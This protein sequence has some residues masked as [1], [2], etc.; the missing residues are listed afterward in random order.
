MPSPSC[1]LGFTTITR[2]IATTGTLTPALLLPAPEQVS[3]ITGLA[4]PDIPSPATPCTP[5]RPCFWLR[6]G[7][8]SD[9][10]CVA[11]GGAS[12]FVHGSLSRQ[13]HQAVSS[14]C[15]GA[16]LPRCSTDYPLTSSCSPPRVAT[17]QLLSATR[18]EAPPVRD[19]TLCAVTLSSARAPVWDRLSSE[20]NSEIVRFESILG[21]LATVTPKAGHRPALRPRGL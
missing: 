5:F 4:L 14:F 6:S 1:P 10:L 16:S 12:D 15:R 3:L 2:F 18:R 11:I 21:S 13:S 20:K 17:T 9:S 19:F 8:A 7:L